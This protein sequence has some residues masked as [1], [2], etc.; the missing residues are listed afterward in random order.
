MLLTLQ[1]A[2]FFFLSNLIFLN[3][4]FL[5]EFSKNIRSIDFRGKSFFL[6][7]SKELDRLPLVGKHT[8][9]LVSEEPISALQSAKVYVTVYFFLKLALFI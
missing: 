9:V 5:V 4:F 1:C 7:V 8:P 2:I 3:L 6:R